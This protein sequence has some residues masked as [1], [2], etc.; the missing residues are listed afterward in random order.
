MSFHCKTH[1]SGPLAGFVADVYRDMRSEGYAV[2]S[3]KQTLSLM[4]RLS[5]WMK[6]RDVSIA[7]LGPD[8]IDEFF[9]H[10]RTKG[11]WH[12]KSSRSMG[13]ILRSLRRS[14]LKLPGPVDRAGGPY[15]ELLGKF[16]SYL[17]MER[18]LTVNVVE[19]YSKV[20][21]RFLRKHFGGR[22]PTLRDL[23]THDVT[24]FVRRK[25][26]SAGIGTSKA[27]V[28]A[29]RAF[30]RWLHVRGEIDLDLADCVP[31][32]ACWRQTS[33][34][35]GLD[36]AE[37][38]RLLRSCDRRTPVGRRDYAVLLL[39][40][41][42]GLRA[43]EV[44]RLMLDDIDWKTAEMSV[45]GKGRKY[46]QLPL[47]HD[48]GEAIAGYLRRGR[49]NHPSRNVFLRSR[50]PFTALEQPAVTTLARRTFQK[51]ELRSPQRGAH[52]LRHTAAT[53]MLRRGGSL[54]E[55][56]QI[57]RHSHIDTTAIY[58]KVDLVSLRELA[59]P[60]PGGES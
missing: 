6:D 41:R 11:Y 20:A 40:V 22:R 35:R 28:T 34:R 13:P 47:P 38:S 17:R 9:R 37:I 55:I 27:Q 39:M 19:S 25:S 54:C 51:V 29:L 12:H 8:R 53:Q 1:I 4:A 36:D 52:V 50:A 2:H 48:V 43:G 7:Q 45:R 46:A 32:I 26:R 42:M 24:E 5:E 56:A 16:A 60:W 49:P 3:V 14:G 58:A 30:L 44:A 18:G 21:G 23:R 31:A 10:R 15:D 57:L 33:L 59:Q